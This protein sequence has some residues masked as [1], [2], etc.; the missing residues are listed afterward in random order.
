MGGNENTSFYHIMNPKSI[1]IKFLYGD[2]DPVSKEWTEGI[3]SDIFRRCANN[4]LPDR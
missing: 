2:S 3:L 1:N 4:T